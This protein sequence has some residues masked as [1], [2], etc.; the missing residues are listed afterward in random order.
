MH[1]SSLPGKYGIGVMGKD[2]VDFVHRLDRGGFRLWQV[3]PLN[4]V[5]HTGSPYCSCSA[6][7]GNV[8]LIDPEW[9]YEKGLIS[10]S[11]LHDN[12]YGGTVYTADYAFAYEKRMKTLREGFSTL[13]EE[14][15]EVVRL[16]AE[17][18]VWA[19]DYAYY[20]ALKD[21]HGG[22]PWWEWE[23]K[24]ARYE[25][26][27]KEKPAFREETEFY[28]FTQYVFFAQCFGNWEHRFR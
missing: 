8:S 5:D 3:L 6:F 20:M 23:D 2:A 22:K 7:A 17:Q 28:L 19:E 16:F 18:N 1:I 10:E 13:A 4:P 25:R 12:E 14:D 24:Y 27:Q 26:A 15:R 21:L 9:L 11:T